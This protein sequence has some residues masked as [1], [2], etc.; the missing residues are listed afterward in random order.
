MP[1]RKRVY[2]KNLTPDE[3]YGSLL[4]SRLI[5]KVMTRGKK[6][7]AKKLVYDALALAAEKSKLGELETLDA[8]VKN[9]SP[10]IQL[11]SR[12]IGGANYQIPTDVTPER[13]LVLALRWLV[14][15]AR[16]RKGRPMA[17]RLSLELVDAINNT[18]GAFK[19]KEE[20]HRMAEANRAFAH[21]SRF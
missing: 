15:A 1:R 5:N 20:T 21:F 18:G 9:V 7:I 8:A 19:K 14:I 6:T 4:V 12:R 17:E 2:H 10:S 11:R 13:R 16:A 3:K